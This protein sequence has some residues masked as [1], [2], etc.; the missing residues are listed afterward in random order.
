MS[1]MPI[2]IGNVELLSLPEAA[3]RLELTPATLRWQV[4]NGTLK[5]EK[6][7]GR[8]L[9]TQ[10]EVARY[11]EQN[12]GQHGNRFQKDGGEDGGE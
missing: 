9:V 10:A 1:P 12:K 7:A 4:K 11:Q 2:R 8:W 6:I 3:E 5:A